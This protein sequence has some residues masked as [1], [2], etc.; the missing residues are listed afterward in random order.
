MAREA[1]ISDKQLRHR[2]VVR[3][4]RDTYLPR[5]VA[6]TLTARVAAVLLTAPPGAVVSHL[7][8]AALWG[9]AIPLQPADG[10][11][12][13]TV[14]TGSSV[15]TRSDRSIHRSPLSDAEVTR[16]RGIPITTRERTWRDLAMMLPQPALL[17]VTDQ[18]LG[19]G[20]TLLDMQ[21]Q[22]ARRPSGRGAARARSVLP[23]ADPRAESP[24]ES[25]LRWLLHEA[26]LPRPVLQ[27]EVRDPGGRFLGRADLAW[28]D[29]KVLV[30]FDGDVHRER[31]VFV[32]DLRR[33]NRLVAAGW[34]VLRFTSADVLGRPD[35]VVR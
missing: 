19:M 30:E 3:L 11:V 8:A 32:N 15:R 25:V 13:I 17:A 4:S 31:D 18:L 34:I 2:D 23:V 28:P 12:H 26:D 1:G 7:T 27:H 10:P 22:L 21:T 6:R 14:G 24:M 16:S 29:R 5:A 9:V 35:A 20:C 33:Q